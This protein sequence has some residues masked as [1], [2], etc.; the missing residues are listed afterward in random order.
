MGN[1]GFIFAMFLVAATVIVE[2]A[3]CVVIGV[4]S[5]QEIE[6]GHKVELRL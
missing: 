3:K 1:K 5:K 6:A 4:V 2:V